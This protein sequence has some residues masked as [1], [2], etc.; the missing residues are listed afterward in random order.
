L[1]LGHEKKMHIQVSIVPLVPVIY[2]Y[3]LA[4]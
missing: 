4:R 1:G 2:F 3:P